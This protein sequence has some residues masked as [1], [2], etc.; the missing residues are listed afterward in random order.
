MSDVDG[1]DGE[2]DGGEGGE[3]I[4]IGVT[5]GLSKDWAGGGVNLCGVDVSGT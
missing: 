5:M 3:N 4:L 1:D 2:G